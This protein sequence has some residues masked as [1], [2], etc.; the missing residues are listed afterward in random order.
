MGKITKIGH[1]QVCK[2]LTP[3]D[4][5]LVSEMLVNLLTSAAPRTRTRVGPIPTNHIRARGRIDSSRFFST[6]GKVGAT[7]NASAIRLAHQHVT[8]SPAGP[9]AG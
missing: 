6:L 7:S 1:A 8:L 5:E 4:A 9:G 2:W 3:L